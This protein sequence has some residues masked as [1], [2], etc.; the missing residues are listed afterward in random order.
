MEQIPPQDNPPEQRC[1]NCGAPTSG[2]RY[3]SFCGQ[4]STTR[5]LSFRELI[6]E[7]MDGLFNMDSRLWHSLVPLIIAPGKLT[8]EYLRGRR[9]FYLPPFRIYLILSVLFFL[10]PNTSFNVNT[11]NGA[12]DGEFRD[13]LSN[14]R[15]ALRQELAEEFRNA[16]DERRSGTETCLNINSQ[17]GSLLSILVRTACQKLIDDPRSFFTALADTMPIVMIVT[18]PLAAILMQL[19]YSFQNRRYVEHIV[20]MFHIHA[21]IFMVSI[22]MGLSSL[23]DMYYPSLAGG[24]NV[25]RLI[26]AWYIPIYVYLAMARV[27]GGSRA[28]IF[29]KALLV[30]TGYLVF[31]GIVT[32]IGA[33]FTALSF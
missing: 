23:L 17:S 15:E 33:L 1:L 13:E 24:M 6:E 22:L 14:E 9:Q 3:C 21:F 27:Y 8:N 12:I 7:F 30:I 31:F 19:L 18:I 10:M 20:F 25:F 26:A 4:K 5:I 11:G 16:A 32:V 28:G 2:L 29:F